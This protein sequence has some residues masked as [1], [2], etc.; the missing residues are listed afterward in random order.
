MIIILKRCCF[1]KKENKFFHE[2]IKWNALYSG[3]EFLTS[4]HDFV[5][6]EF[7]VNSLLITFSLAI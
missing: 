6:M 1:K 3:I 4:I 5:L 7:S 2:V